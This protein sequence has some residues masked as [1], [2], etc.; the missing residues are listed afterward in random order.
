MAKSIAV[1]PF[2]EIGERLE[3]IL[4]IERLVSCEIRFS[5]GEPVTAKTKELLNGEQVESFLELMDDGSWRVEAGPQRAK[6]TEE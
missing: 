4:G 5:V 2:G 3:K 6:V 1:I